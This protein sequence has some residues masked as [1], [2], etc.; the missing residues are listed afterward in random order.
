MDFKLYMSLIP[1]CV[2]MQLSS[3]YMETPK[4]Q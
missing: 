1:V 4:Q 3:K 2:W